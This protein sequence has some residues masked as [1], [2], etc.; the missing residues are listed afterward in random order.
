M[1]CVVTMTG[2]NWCVAVFKC[3]PS[4]IRKVLLDFYRFVED[5]DGVKSL[6]FLI[7]DRAKDE[8]VFSF[9]VLAEK[10]Q[11]HI[12][13][14]KMAYKLGTQLSEERF[15]VD[16]EI[17]HPLRKYVEWSE[18]RIAKCGTKKFAEFYTLLEKMSKLVIQMI[19]RK[20]FSSDERAEIA[21]V[22]SWMLGCTEYGL[23]STKHMEVGYYDRIE[24]KNCQYLKQDFPQP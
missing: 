10:E 1:L 6:H 18:E 14:S 16:P 7:R 21:H 11:K 22:M 3:K 24:D 9:R 13:S 20:Y 17:K 23:L 8:V 4:D 15:A 5:L 2:D 19:R 12:V